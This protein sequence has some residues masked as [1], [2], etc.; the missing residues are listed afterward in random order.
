LLYPILIKGIPDLSRVKYVQL[1]LVATQLAQPCGYW[2]AQRRRSGRLSFDARDR[3]NPWLTARNGPFLRHEVAFFTKS[4]RRII[5]LGGKARPA[6]T[7]G[8]RTAA[9]TVPSFPTH[10]RPQPAANGLDIL[11]S[12]LA[13]FDLRSENA[14]FTRSRWNHKAADGITKTAEGGLDSIHF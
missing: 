4:N 9:A 2:Q 8:L 7:P 1:L 3:Q 6:C 14:H 12:E 5:L 10:N 13:K 11:Q